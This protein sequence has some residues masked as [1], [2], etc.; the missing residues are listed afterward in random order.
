MPYLHI[1]GQGEV[2]PEWMALKAIVCQDAPQVRVVG[3]EHPIHVPHLD[4]HK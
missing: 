4:T 2:L 3:K 1:S